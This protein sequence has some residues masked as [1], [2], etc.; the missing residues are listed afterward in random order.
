M[1]PC[2]KKNETFSPSC[3]MANED[4]TACPPEV[5]LTVPARAST[6]WR[7]PVLEVTQWAAVS[8]HWSQRMVLP[9]LKRKQNKKHYDR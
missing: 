8:S 9:Q 4:M 3:G 6:D 2:K 1:T 7:V 5:A